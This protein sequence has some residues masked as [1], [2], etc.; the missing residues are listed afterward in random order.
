M[1]EP[2]GESTEL[3]KFVINVNEDFVGEEVEAIKGFYNGVQLRGVKSKD[4]T[5][6]VEFG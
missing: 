2:S 5:E 4:I 1:A 3:I 6:L